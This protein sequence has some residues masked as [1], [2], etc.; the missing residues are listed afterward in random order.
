MR[1][2][3]S[4]MIALPFQCVEAFF[5][6]FAGHFPPGMFQIMT[7]AVLALFLEYKRCS[8]SAMA[9]KTGRKCQ[10]LQYFLAESKWDDLQQINQTR[11]QFIYSRRA[12]RPTRRGVN[13]LDDTGNP[14]RS[15]RHTEGVAKQYCGATKNTERCHV[16]VFS[17][18]ADASKHFPVH[19]RTYKPSSLF[20]DGEQNPEFHSKIDIAADFLR[21][22][23][24]DPVLPRK[25][26]ADC[27]YA[28]VKLIEL[29]VSLGLTYISE[30]RSNRLLLFRHPQ[31][32]QPVYINAE[33]LVKLIRVHFRDKVKYVRCPTAE[34]PT[35]KVP[36]YSFESRL[37]DCHVPVKVVAVL[38]K[39]FEDDEESARILFSTDPKADAQEIVDDYRLR[40]GIERVFAEL[41][42]LF[43]FDQY[44]TPRLKATERYW[45]LCILDWTLAYYLKQT[46]ALRRTVTVPQETLSGVVTAV[47][48]VLERQRHVRLVSLPPEQA[49]GIRSQRVLK[50]L[51][52]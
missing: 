2:S 19:F 43:Y 27:W 38:D 18:Y 16:I 20:K 47:R 17:A 51:A 29:A 23:A 1:K 22:I 42:D 12:T 14:K 13:V 49:Y 40:W 36:V 26:V 15:A 37:Q 46:G 31:T 3:G 34:N 44:Q 8:F 32:R 24:G 41:K 7:E 28:A 30:I 25:V 9:R 10:N 33:E 11:L 35:R 52:A 39:L 45:M 48:A 5:A 50:R 4:P 6:L 21:G